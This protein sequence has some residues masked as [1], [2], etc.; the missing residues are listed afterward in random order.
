MSY[1]SCD[2]KAQHMQQP[3]TSSYS[4]DQA[5]TTQT[6]NRSRKP[7]GEDVLQY[8]FATT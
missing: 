2:I 7:P 3:H 8:A 5:V 1:F 6:F 4:Y